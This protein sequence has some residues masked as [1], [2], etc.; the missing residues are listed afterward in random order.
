M[1]LSVGASNTV[2]D[3][4]VISDDSD[5]SD[6]DSSKTHGLTS[7]ADNESILQFVEVSQEVDQ[8]DITSDPVMASQLVESPLPSPPRDT[9]EDDIS[10]PVP[11]KDTV[12]GKNGGVSSPKKPYRSLRM[13]AI[14]SFVV[15]KKMKKRTKKSARKTKKSAK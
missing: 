15:K 5:G 10:P 14:N 13:N 3:I 12:A 11:M 6:R 4:I 8:E 1:S 2:Q 9:E 7:V